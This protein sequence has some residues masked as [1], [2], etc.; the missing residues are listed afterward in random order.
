[1]FALKWS[2]S[3]CSRVGLLFT[4]EEQEKKEKKKKKLAC[5]IPDMDATHSTPYMDAT[6]STRSHDAT[7]SRKMFF[8]NYSNV[9]KQNKTH[10]N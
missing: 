10:K 3:G 1:M 8:F 5:D 4:N 9:K 2:S 7:A 6:H